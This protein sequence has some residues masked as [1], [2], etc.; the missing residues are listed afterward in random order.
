MVLEETS[1][2]PVSKKRPTLDNLDFPP[3]Y[4]VPVI[5]GHP[6]VSGHHTPGV[7]GQVTW[8]NGGFTGL[9]I[10]ASGTTGKSRCDGFIESW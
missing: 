2:V 5:R 1:K 6:V 10:G 8:D 4:W 3:C 9:M 7:N